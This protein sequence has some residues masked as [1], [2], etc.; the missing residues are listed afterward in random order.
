MLALSNYMAENKFMTVSS[1]TMW[2]ML[3]VA[4]LAMPHLS[5]FSPSQTDERAK[6]FGNLFGNKGGL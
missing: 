6:G 2:E 1:V 4:F 5:F 3:L